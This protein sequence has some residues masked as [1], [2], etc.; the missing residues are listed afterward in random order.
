V[1]GRFEIIRPRD[2]DG[3]FATEERKELL[4]DDGRELAIAIDLISG[5]PGQQLLLNKGEFVAAHVLKRQ[6]VTEGENF[7]VHKE[8]VVAGIV[9]DAKVVAEGKQFLFQNVAHKIQ[10]I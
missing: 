7:A 8:N 1:A 6:L 3:E 4:L 10:F 5:S 9:L 2:I